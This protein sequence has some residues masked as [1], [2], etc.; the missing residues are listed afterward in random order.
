MP[1]LKN[2]P[3]LYEI[4]GFMLNFIY[5]LTNINVLCIFHQLT[6]QNFTSVKKSLHFLS[7]IKSH[8]WILTSITIILK[9]VFEPQNMPSYIWNKVSL[10]A[11]TQYATMS[12]SLP[13]P[14][15]KQVR[16]YFNYIL[17]TRSLKRCQDIGERWLQQTDLQL[18]SL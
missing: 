14:V 9:I 6:K 8:K 1:P 4:L 3:H 17:I 18:R 2:I 10:S 5:P 12:K 7:L 11:S 13:L 16:A 15:F